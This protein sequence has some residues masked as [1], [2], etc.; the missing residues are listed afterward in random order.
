MSQQQGQCSIQGGQLERHTTVKGL[1]PL[2]VEGDKV[3][4]RHQLTDR[5]KGVLGYAQEGHLHG[6]KR[7]ISPCSQEP[8]T[9]EYSGKDKRMFNDCSWGTWL[10][11]QNQKESQ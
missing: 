7:L 4:I 2:A 11:L 8:I 9:L 6:A 5:R 1:W 3:Y 10:E